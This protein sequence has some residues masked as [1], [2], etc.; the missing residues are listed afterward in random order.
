M[1][2]PDHRSQ[3]RNMSSFTAIIF[4]QA[5]LLGT[6]SAPPAEGF[7]QAEVILLAQAGQQQKPA[8]Q[9]QEVPP[10]RRPSGEDRATVQ[11]A[12]NTEPAH[13]RARPASRRRDRDGIPPGSEVRTREPARPTPAQVTDI[14]GSKSKD[15]DQRSVPA[16]E[17]TGAGTFTRGATGADQ[18]MNNVDPPSPNNRPVRKSDERATSGAE[19]AARAKGGSR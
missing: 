12:G 6:A 15:Q 8:Q 16:Q 7:R 9:K 19:G 5:L 4:G 10:P 2:A 18:P 13:P 17:N 11:P 3:E 14:A 1:V